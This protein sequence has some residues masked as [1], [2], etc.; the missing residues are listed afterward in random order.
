MRCI[1]VC[2]AGLIFAL[3]VGCGSNPAPDRLPPPPAQP[4]PDAALLKERVAALAKQVREAMTDPSITQLPVGP[5]ADTGRGREQ[6]QAAQPLMRKL[7]ECGKA[8]E[9]PLWQLINDP[10]ESVRRSSVFLL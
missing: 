2:L 8:A 3:A 7:V 1:A 6:I 4:Q 9:E 5:T 10:D